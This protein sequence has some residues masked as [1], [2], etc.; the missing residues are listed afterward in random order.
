VL[1]PLRLSVVIPCYNEIYTIREVLRR[2]AARPEV[3]E[4]IVVDDGS[5]DGTRERL[6]EFEAARAEAGAARPAVRVVYKEKNE[7]KGAALVCGFRQATGDVVLIQDADLEYDPSDY[8]KLLA[9]IADGRA[10]VVYGSRFM[11]GERNVLL[12][13]HTVANRIL[14]LI[15]NI[16]TNLNLTDVW[17]CYKVFR[18]EI[19]GRIP[20]KSRGFNFEAEVTIKLAKLGC[21]ITEVPIRYAGRTA[22]EGKKIR[23]KDAVIG[24]WTTLMTW[25]WGDLGDLAVGEQTLRVMATAGRYNQLMRDM[26]AP[27]LGRRVVEIGAGVGNISRF[28]LDRDQVTLTDADPIYVRYLRRQYQGWS[29]VSVRQFDL[30]KTDADALSGKFDTAVCF[31]VVEHINDDATALANLRR[32]LEPGGRLLLIVPAHMWLF[33]SLDEHLGHFRRYEK[34]E[35]AAKLAAAGFELERADYYNPIAV[36]GWY[37]NGK[38]LKRR[39]IPNFQ[40]ALFD[41]L[42]PLV[43]LSMGSELTFGLSLF[44]VARRPAEAPAR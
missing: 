14:T 34:E 28:L 31:N 43:R 16:F 32:L 8:P 23:F 19:I 35:L 29:Y 9:P 18:A 25:A 21:R 37:V 13:W 40:M 42:T 44:A 3:Q 22:A 36:P 15:S 30:L 39:V 17:T 27:H 26:F 12:F 10:D 7:G 20:L 6:R 33:G 11:S 2:V 24:F 4:I 38:W 1:E 41:R 5:T